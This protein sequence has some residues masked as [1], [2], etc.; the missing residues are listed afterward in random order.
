[1]CHAFDH[2]VNPLPSTLLKKEGGGGLQRPYA[3]EGR[4]VESP[5]CEKP[6]VYFS[7]SSQLMAG[8]TRIQRGEERI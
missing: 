8:L 3:E 7:F 5:V 2:H 4:F 6:L 1:M